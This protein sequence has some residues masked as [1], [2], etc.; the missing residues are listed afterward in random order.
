[1]EQTSA[2]SSLVPDIEKVSERLV[3]DDKLSDILWVLRLEQAHANNNC[4]TSNCFS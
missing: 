2:G 3:I 1:M 4:V